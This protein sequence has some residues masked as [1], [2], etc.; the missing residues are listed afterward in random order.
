MSRALDEEFF[1]P[2]R[3]LHSAGDRSFIWMGVQHIE[4][5]MAVLRP[6]LLGGAGE[7]LGE[8]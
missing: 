2:D 1:A 6:T 4:S 8:L 7:A 3:E 5:H